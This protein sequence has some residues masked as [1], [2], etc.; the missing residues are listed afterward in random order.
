[1]FVCLFVCLFG[2]YLKVLLI[3][4]KKKKKGN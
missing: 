3:F 4:K 2:L 1:L